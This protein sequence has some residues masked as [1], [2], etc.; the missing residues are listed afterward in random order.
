MLFGLSDVFPILNDDPVAIWNDLQPQR[1]H[2]SVLGTWPGFVWIA[3]FTLFH[4]FLDKIIHSKATRCAEN[5]VK[6][7]QQNRLIPAPK[8]M[9]TSFHAD[10]SKIHSTKKLTA[11]HRSSSTSS[12]LANLFKKHNLDSKINN[13]NENEYR[14]QT[15]T[16]H[17]Q[18]CNI[19]KNIS[20]FKESFFKVFGFGLVYF[21]GIIILSDPILSKF[22][23][24]PSI[25]C[26]AWPQ[27]PGDIKGSW[28][29]LNY[30]YWLQMGYHGHRALYQFFEYARKDFWAMFI[31]HWVA[32]FLL[33]GSYGA[34]YQQIGS[35]VLLCND[36]LDLIMPLAKICGLMGYDML[37]KMFFALFAILWIPFR[38]V[39]YFNKVLMLPFGCAYY[40]HVRPYIA[41]WLLVF[42]LCIIY[43]LQLYWT[44]FLLQMLYKKF[45]KGEKATDTRSD[46]ES[47]A[48]D[49]MSA[50]QNSKKRQ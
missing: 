5:V 37:H 46:D 39:M 24:D 35:M 33:I 11:S 15:I 48:S 17:K 18:L 43:A 4:Y 44:K 23:W 32:L 10:L 9:T 50:R 1:W 28:L 49:E 12:T 13:K 25:Q 34:G 3:V 27:W 22:F 45:V 30:Y 31:H 36:N 14:M 16:Y 26:T 8:W 42:G 7:S 21:Y 19:N 40:T 6:K 29:N 38:V 2:Q 47:G 41:H 20:K